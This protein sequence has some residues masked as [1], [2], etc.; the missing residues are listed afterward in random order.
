MM[1]SATN[2]TLTF[3]LEWKPVAAKAAPKKPAKAPAKGKKAAP[4]Q[5]APAPEAEPAEQPEPKGRTA[6]LTYE[7]LG[8][9]EFLLTSARGLQFRTPQYNGRLVKTLLALEYDD[10]DYTRRPT[11]RVLLNGAVVK[12]SE[13][14]Y[15]DDEDYGVYGDMMKYHQV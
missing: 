14:Q 8:P 9:E 6:T 12:D 1:M 3:V 13:V 2:P 4:L 11:L 10:M 7:Q 5:A 15:Y